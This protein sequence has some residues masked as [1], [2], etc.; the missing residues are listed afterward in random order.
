MFGVLGESRLGSRLLIE[1]NF[2]LYLQI[3][4]VYDGTTYELILISWRKGPRSADEEHA[5]SILLALAIVCSFLHVYYR[6][7]Q[8]ML[9]LFVTGACACSNENATKIRAMFPS[10]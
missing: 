5:A 1:M 9:N 4:P 8:R 7:K 3:D 10:S 6:P 2:G